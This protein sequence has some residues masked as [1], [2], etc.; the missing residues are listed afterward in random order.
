M[1]K[2]LNDV[3]YDIALKQFGDKTFSFNDLWSKVVSISRIKKSEADEQVGEFYTEIMQDP[4]F[5]YCK[6]NT[7][8]LKDFL[9]INDA[10]NSEKFLYN[11]NKTD[12][13]EEGYEDVKKIVDENDEELTQDQREKTDEEIAAEFG[14]DCD[15]EEAYNDMNNQFLKQSDDEKE[16]EE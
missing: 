12:V 9:S 3:A 13:Y 11:N 14:Y 1:G 6:D 10:K 15:V 2:E 16:D 7:W 5:V 4:R 8:K